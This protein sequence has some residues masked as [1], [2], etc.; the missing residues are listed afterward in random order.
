MQAHVRVARATD[1][2]DE[3]LRFYGDGLGF[4]RVGEFHD[5]EG[6]DG[7]MLGPPGGGYHL[8]FTREHGV[9]AGRAP[10]PENLLVFYLPDAAAWREATGRMEALGYGAVASHNPYWDRN[11]KTYEDADGYRVVLYHGVWENRALGA[12]G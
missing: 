5:H 10:G 8:E 11:G 12:S 4:A 7:V 6:F 3:I 9:A 2:L 1:H